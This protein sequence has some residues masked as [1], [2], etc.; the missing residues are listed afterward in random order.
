MVS[1]TERERERETQREREAHRETHTERGTHVQLL[2]F[3]A[4]VTHMCYFLVVAPA[5]PL[6]ASLTL[7]HSLSSLSARALAR[8]RHLSRARSSL[9]RSPARSRRTCLVKEKVV[10]LRER[11]EL[12]FA[13]HRRLGRVRQLRRHRG[14]ADR[15]ALSRGNHGK[16]MGHVDGR[17]CRSRQGQRT[18]A[19]LTAA[20]LRCV[21]RA[22]EREKRQQ[23]SRRERAARA[24]PVSRRFSACRR[25]CF[26][27]LFFRPARRGAH[28]RQWR[29]MS[30][31]AI[32]R[33]R[34]F[35]AFPVATA[36]V[37]SRA[38]ARA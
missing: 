11:A 13:L 3:F 31:C 36:R 29:R 30:W 22:Q 4:A 26:H 7:S 18:R 16:A 27:L 32:A 25:G 33:T 21:E 15:N 14:H 2:S 1:C 20:C 37:R 28:A 34:A 17:T 9:A 35:A 8:A 6:T 23:G 19:L 10:Q 24:R 12:G 5:A 38:R